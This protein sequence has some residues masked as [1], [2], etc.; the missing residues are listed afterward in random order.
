MI[1]LY[2]H[3]P[4]CESKCIYCDFYSI[5]DHSTKHEFIKSLINEIRNE[6]VNL[7]DKNIDTIFIGGGTPS[8][9]LKPDFEKLFE[10]LYT[11]L[12]ISNDSEITIEANPGTLDKNK[13]KEFKKLPINR[14]SFGV[15]S[16][17]DSDLKF[18]SRIHNSKQAEDSIKYAQ[19]AGYS[20]VNLDL[21]FSIPGQTIDNWAYNLEKAVNLNTQH[22]SA[23][24]LIFEEGTPLYSLLKQNKVKNSNIE[25]ERDMYDYTMDYL[26][27]NGFN[28][29]EISNYAKPGYECRHN[30]KYWQ[31]EEYI[32][33]GPSAASYLNNYRR[34][35]VRDVDRYI[36]SINHG[37]KP[38]DALEFIDEQT[39]QN[40]FIMLG[41]RSK[42]INF[43]EFKNKYKED[44]KS[45][46]HYPIE[47][48]TKGGLASI[49]ADC[50]RLTQRGYALC[51]EIL[52]TYF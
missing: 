35:N 5:N 37:E 41:M 36:D 23:Y 7:K 45:K 10:A 22:I 20:N 13:L 24:S 48:L 52:A 9:L 19:D 8:L 28:Q 15:Q 29:Y 42:G 4:F 43:S 21:I 47:I 51:D 17:I 44:F 18:L 3:I 12:D 31:H 6:S 16:F 33:F 39:S 2:I 25:I 14:I 34:I 27:A 30:L 11:Y 1:G 38:Y 40:E 50:I 26:K 32:G 46:Y 49:E